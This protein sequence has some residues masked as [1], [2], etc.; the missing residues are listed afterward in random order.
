MAIAGSRRITQLRASWCQ[1][2]P[3]SP[4]IVWVARRSSRPRIPPWGR[5][6]RRA[7]LAEEASMTAP[8]DIAVRRALEAAGVEFIDENGGGPGV[9]RASAQEELTPEGNAAILVL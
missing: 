4:G 2:R 1:R 6:D 5:N 3:R 7:E 9:R 8:N